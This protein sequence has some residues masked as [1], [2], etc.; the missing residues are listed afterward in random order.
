MFTPTGL[1][2]CPLYAPP[3]NLQG[4]KLMTTLAANAD[5]WLATYGRRGLSGIATRR[6]S[7]SSVAV[8]VGILVWALANAY[9]SQA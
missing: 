4:M 1:S 6:I 5:S 9:L 7:L 3:R 8:C 2:L